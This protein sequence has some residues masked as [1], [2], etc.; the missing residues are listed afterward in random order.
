[1]ELTYLRVS[2]RGSQIGGTSAFLKEGLRFSIHDLLH[3][4]M[5]PSGNDA[6]LVLSEHFG[7]Y[8]MLLS[9]K[10]NSKNFA[11]IAELN[12][13]DPDVCKMFTKKFC[14]KMN[15]TANQLKMNGTNYNNPHGLSDKANK[16]TVTDQARLSVLAMKNP[17][18][19]EI[20]S[21]KHYTS[22][23]VADC[24]DMQERGSAELVEYWWRNSNKLLSTQ[25]FFGCKTGFTTTAGSC[26]SSCYKQ[27][28]VNLVTVLVGARTNDHR[29]TE[30]A[31]LVHWAER[32]LRSKPAKRAES[33]NV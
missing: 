27:G 32:Q 26:L 25:G 5:L 31:K 20:V 22:L 6:A 19:N 14:Q 7:R 1:M 11:K 24:R 3:G 16:S 8:L 13:F 33:Q 17:I 10:S 21:K 30:T 15:Q 12:P 9:C 28:S 29:F 18:F 23:L 2:K 4:L